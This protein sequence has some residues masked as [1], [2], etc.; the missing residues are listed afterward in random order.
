[1]TDTQAFYAIVQDK[2]G[3]EETEILTVETD[4]NGL[5]ILELT[6]GTRIVCTEEVVAA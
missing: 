5:P 3:D 4:M 2:N 6:D 1:M